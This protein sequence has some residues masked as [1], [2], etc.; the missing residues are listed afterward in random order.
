MISQDYVHVWHC[1]ISYYEYKETNMPFS[2]MKTHTIF[3]IDFK[4]M[5]KNKN[6]ITKTGFMK[7][8]LS[9]VHNYKYLEILI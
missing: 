3:V 1:H 9:Y 4:V 8:L 7:K 6:L 2:K 5:G